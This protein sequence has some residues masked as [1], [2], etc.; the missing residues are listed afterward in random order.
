[1]LHLNRNLSVERYWFAV[2]RGFPNNPLGER[3]RLSLRKDHRD[4]TYSTLHH[5]THVNS[6]L[7]SRTGPKSRLQLY[8]TFF[9]QGGVFRLHPRGAT[10][11]IG[12][13]RAPHGLVASGWGYAVAD[14]AGQRIVEFAIDGSGIAERRDIA[15]PGCDWIQDIEP[16]GDGYLVADCNNRRILEVDRAGRAQKSWEYNRDWKIQELMLLR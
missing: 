4:I 3:R 10:K 1:V 15:L 14:T 7:W 12:G 8:A 2:K 6:L 9:H 5:T 11:I 13:L 16:T